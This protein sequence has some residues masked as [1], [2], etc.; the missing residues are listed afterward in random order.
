ATPYTKSAWDVYNQLKLFHIED[1]TSVPINPP[2][3][4]DF[5]S[6][7]EARNRDLSEL[8]SHV[9]VRRTRQ[10][11]LEEYGRE[12]ETGREYLKMG[13]ERRYLP[14]RHL[15]TEDYG[16]HETY[17]DED[18]VSLY[19]S[20]L[21][22]VEE[23]TFVRYS[24]GQSDYLRPEFADQEPYSNL[25]SMGRS[26]RGLM[27]SNLL[28]R[29]ESS[30]PA[31]YDSLERMLGSHRVFRRLLD[32]GTVAV[33]GNLSE[34]INSGERVETILSE[35]DRVLEDDEQAVYDPEAFYVDK[36]KTDLENDIE[37][38][39]KL[40]ERL[41]PFYAAVQ[42]NP[43]QDDKAEQFRQI[44]SNLWFGSHDVL[45]RRDSA[46]KIIVFTQFADTARYLGESLGEFQRRGELPEELSYEVT[47]G[48]SA[49]VEGTIQRFAP[50]A[51]DARDAVTTEEE[52]DIL[53]PTDVAGEGVNLQDA[54]T[55][56]N[57]DLHWNPLRLIQRIGRVDRLGS[58]HDDIYALNFLPETELEEAL[59]I[60]ERV[61]RRVEE[62]GRVLGEDGEILSPEDNINKKYM[63]KIYQEEDFE[64]VETGVNEILGSDDLAGPASDLRE[65]RQR[66]PD[67]LAWLEDRDGIRTTMNWDRPHDAVVIVYKQGEYATPYLVAFNDGE[68]NIESEQKNEIV[69]TVSCAVDEPV[70]TV[71]QS[72][73]TDRYERAARTARQAFIR[74]MGERL[75]FQ[76]ESRRRAS[77]DRQYVVDQLD[78]VI[79]EVDNREQRETLQRYRSIVQTTS[80]G[81]VID[82]F[83]TLRQN[84][85]AGDDTVDAVVEIISRYN[86]EDQFE[87]R[88]EWANTQDE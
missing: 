88:R 49:S 32:D 41:E 61:E 67:L 6:E 71:D 79:D 63:E 81:Q 36:L 70:A 56:I 40:K 60:V 84:G 3:L 87:Q 20:I 21:D 5:V 73:F 19:S 57:Y 2:N 47:T 55:V 4:Q 28:K 1:V 18:G 50:D 45:R 59:G 78:R 11:I 8:L 24:L 44:V 76:R 74:E 39:A 58:E 42:E 34:L 23:L 53:L 10:D 7:V 13:D 83:G 33:G 30:L 65:L 86:L 26:I 29:L 17:A 37:L 85:V 35:V 14:N 9:M 46:N 64:G 66:H 48:D 31:F 51:N 15:Q 22:T 43:K 38:L 62:I 68:A 52:I 72:T 80:A 27:K 75:K 54:N 25:S 12:D 82:E 69:Q 77:A 16:L